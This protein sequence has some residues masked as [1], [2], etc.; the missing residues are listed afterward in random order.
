MGDRISHADLFSIRKY[1][2]TIAKMR[3]N[4]H[5]N[6]IIATIRQFY[7]SY[8]IYDFKRLGAI[9]KLAR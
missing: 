7:Q 6:R 9:V 5:E 4:T 2:I 3:L 8:N 1:F